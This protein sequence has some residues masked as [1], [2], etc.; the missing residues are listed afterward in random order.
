MRYQPLIGVAMPDAEGADTHGSL[1]Q[2]LE[3]SGS[4][5]ELVPPDGR[6]A[7]DTI[8]PV[9][10]LVVAEVDGDHAEPVLAMLR[11]ADRRN[12]PTLVVGGGMHLMNLAFGGA[13]RFRPTDGAPALHD[14][15]PANGTRLSAT[16]KARPL[17]CSCDHGVVVDRVA[18]G[19]AVSARSNDGQIEAIERGKLDMNAPDAG[20]MLGVAWH[21]ERTAGEDAAQRRLFD[22]MYLLSRWRGQVVHGEGTRPYH[23]DDPDPAWPSAFEH[24]ERLLRDTLPPELVVRIDH[25]GS[26]SVPNL[27]AKPVIDIQ[28]AVTSMI[29]VDAYAEPLHTVGYHQAIDPWNDDHEFFSTDAT[30]TLRDVH[31]HVCEAGSIWEIRH[32]AFRDWLR[33]H[34]DDAAAYG[35]LKRRLAQAHPRDIVAYLD[36]KGAFIERLTDIAVAHRDDQGRRD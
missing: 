12:M 16:T 9:D 33:D 34:P 21:P 4:R 19:C 1:V 31:V 29:P 10:G 35:A 17:R 32:L 6:P 23:V 13:G 36:G 26:T 20:W 28:L 8:D 11:E 14:L 30:Q 3:R 25:V 18:G 22:A 5:T 15:D 24:E 27:P 2:A 7:S